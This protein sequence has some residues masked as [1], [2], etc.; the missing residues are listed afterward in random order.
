MAKKLLIEKR[1]ERMQKN[2]FYISLKDHKP[3]F[4]DKKTYR[5]IN[6]TKW[7]VGKISKSISDKINRRV[8]TAT[9]PNQWKKYIVQFRMV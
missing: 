5:S 6:R 7:D 9:K 3:G 8:L 1:I 2:E 4:P